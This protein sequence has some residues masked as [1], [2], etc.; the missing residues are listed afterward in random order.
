[1]YNMN[2]MDISLPGTMATVGTNMSHSMAT[3]HPTNLINII[4]HCAT[5]CDHMITHLT[6]HEEMNNRRLQ[7]QLLRDCA[8]ICHVTAS[9][10]ARNSHLNKMM[11][12][13]CAQICEAC[14]N[15]CSKFND[16]HSQHCAQVCYHCAQ[17]CR[18]FARAA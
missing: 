18:S 3:M 2:T 13:I 17:E 1:M 5:T 6:N 16:R 9:F 4:Q 15:E 12:Q 11:A 7:L 8:D 14:G 10:I